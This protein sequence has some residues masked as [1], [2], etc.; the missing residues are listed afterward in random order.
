MNDDLDKIEEDLKKKDQPKKEEKISGRSVFKLKEIIQ[1]K[2]KKVNI[3]KENSKE[4]SI[5]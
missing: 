2:S 3:S 1:E 5:S 4:N